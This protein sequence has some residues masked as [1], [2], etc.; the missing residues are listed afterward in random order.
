MIED[1]IVKSAKSENL[2]GKNY[3][4]NNRT[5]PGCTAEDIVSK[6][7]T[8]VIVYQ[9]ILYQSNYLRKTRYYTSSHW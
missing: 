6:A 2:I 3:V 8:K 9:S 7:I 5:N 4:E 1:C